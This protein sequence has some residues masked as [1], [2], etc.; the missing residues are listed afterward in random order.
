MASTTTFSCDIC[1]NDATRKQERVQ[2]AFNSDQDEGRYCK[3]YLDIVTLDLCTECYGKILVNH[4]IQAW[5]AQ[6]H[7]TYEMKQPA[8][9]NANSEAVRVLCDVL[10]KAQNQLE[11]IYNRTDQRS[12]RGLSSAGISFTREA[13]ATYGREG[14]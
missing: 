14:E 1:K 9:M 2:V 13:L 7:N 3:P 12:I 10:Q 5:G 4:P 11:K 8:A 6:G